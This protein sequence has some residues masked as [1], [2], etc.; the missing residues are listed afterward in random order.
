[1]SSLDKAIKSKQRLHRE[2]VN[3][4]SKG[5]LERKKDYKVR[6]AEFHRRQE[7]ITK[8][9]KKTLDKNPDEFFFQMKS[10]KLVD[11]VHYQIR[12]DDDELSPEEL[13][14]MQTQDLSYINFKRSIDQRKIEKLQSELHLINCTDKPRNK[15]IFFV[16]KTKDKKKVN[17][18][19]RMNVDSNLLA[20]G[21]NIANPIALSNVSV[22]DI[23]AST[24]V[25]DLKYRRLEN[26]MNREQK[27][28][29]LSKRM[30]LKKKLLNQKES[31]KLVRKGKANRPPV[32]KWKTERKK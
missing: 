8:L 5:F 22:K 21:F 7:I 12:K 14:L 25:K 9:R 11:G 1:M 28:T 13:Q 30:E 19:E 23:E 31:A 15:H 6:A 32:Y 2:R 17:F 26:K 27:L 16:E 10:S 20:M 3:V 4:L 29:A 18:A 24:E